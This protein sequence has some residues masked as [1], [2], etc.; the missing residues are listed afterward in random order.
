M[1]LEPPPMSTWRWP[2]YAAGA[3]MIGFGVWG[4]L[5][6]ADTN[7]RRYG[8]LL[9]VAALGHDLVLAPVVIA[10]GVV[11]RRVLPRNAHAPLQSA[12]I[13]GFVLL[14]I[15][16][17]GLGHFGAK[18]DNRSILPLDYTKGLMIAL[19]VVAA[20]TVLAVLVRVVR[21]RR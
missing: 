5:F 18:S 6:G 21:Q 16:I 20:G 2:L 3:A 12:A 1:S 15:A 9:L 11:A 13:I 19:G 14:L 4:Q 17:P 10:L 8:E 7:P